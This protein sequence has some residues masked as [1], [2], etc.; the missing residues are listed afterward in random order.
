MDRRRTTVIGAITLAGAA[1]VAGLMTLGPAAQAATFDPCSA[2]GHGR[3]RHTTGSAKHLVFAISSAYSSNTVVVTECAKSGKTWKKVSQTTGRAGT[4]GFA[5]PGEKREGDGKSPTGSF[6]LS[7]A[8][9]MGDPGTALPYRKLRSTGDC[10]GSTPGES[11]YN[12]YYSGTCRSTDED[13]SATMKRGPYHQVVVID[14]N[15]PKPVPG[16]GSAIF[17]H[18]GGKTPTAGCI[19]ITEGRLKTVMKTLVKGDRMI[20][21]PK[22]ALF[23]S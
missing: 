12:A 16:Y 10:W 9:G 5:K 8:F 7:S 15:L 21:G 6:T 14:Y 4:K 13:L 18:V 22:S 2:A 23:T 3:L 20:M 11:H 19:S 1:A 17:F